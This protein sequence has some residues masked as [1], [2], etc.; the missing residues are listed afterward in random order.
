V[1]DNFISQYVLHSA[2]LFEVTKA[3]TEESLKQYHALKIPH[4]V[5]HNTTHN[6]T[7]ASA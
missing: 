6:I 1:V 5:T 7:Q 4:H 3:R 2:Y